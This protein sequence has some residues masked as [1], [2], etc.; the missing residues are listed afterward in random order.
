MKSCRLPH[1]IVGP[2]HK[3]LLDRTY[4]L[5]LVGDIKLGGDFAH[6]ETN[7]GNVV[8]D[9]THVEYLRDF[10]IRSGH[11]YTL[12]ITGLRL[13]ATYSMRNTRQRTTYARGVLGMTLEEMG[14]AFAQPSV[15]QQVKS[16]RFLAEWKRACC[17]ITVRL[18]T[19][20]N[21]RMKCRED[22]E[23]EWIGNGESV[24]LILG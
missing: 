14:N 3:H 22:K 5:E 2:E 20:R 13:E 23:V 16:G 24:G 1:L 8:G 12:R 6:D 7:S 4:L 18:F 10:Q 21:V 15:R 19:Y 11:Q 9:I 17:S